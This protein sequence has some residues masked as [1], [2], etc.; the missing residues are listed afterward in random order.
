MSKS[1]GTNPIGEAFESFRK[2]DDGARFK[3]LVSRCG[4]ASKGE[5]IRAADLGPGA[6]I[7]RLVET[8]AIGVIHGG[9]ETVEQSMPG[10]EPVI[11][12]RTDPKKK[13]ELPRSLKP[14]PGTALKDD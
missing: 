13:P 6:E 8:G 4:S 1:F 10:R 9:R 7:D 14:E 3:V 5:I 11:E 12:Q 2:K